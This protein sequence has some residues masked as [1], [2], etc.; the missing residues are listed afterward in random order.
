MTESEKTA[1]SDGG[2]KQSA[3]SASSGPSAPA[4]PPAPA[5]PGDAVDGDDDMMLVT[6]FPPPPYY[7]HL[8]SRSA[9]SDR[10]LRPP[11][12]PHNAFRVAAKRVVA[13]RRKAREESERI[14]HESEKK[15]G[16]AAAGDDVV[17]RDGAP[18]R[19]SPVEDDD[20]IDPD[21]ESEPVV[22]VFGEIVEDPTLTAEEECHDPAAIRENVRMLNRAVLWR[23]LDLVRKLARDP[24]DAKRDRDEL[25]HNIFLMLQECNKFREHQAREILIA[26]LEEQLEER[27]RGL[28]LLRKQIGEADD[29]LERLQERGLRR[30]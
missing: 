8:A 16:D 25:S 10:R 12:I 29:A 27:T 28:D 19:R 7:Y 17:M 26:A 11:E 30:S 2:G 6:E 4:A 1:S 20:S 22:S 3:S 14:R 9:P 15:D 5:P 24:A 13:Q 18:D 21:D 23:F